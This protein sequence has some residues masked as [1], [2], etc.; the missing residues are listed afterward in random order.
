MKPETSRVQ[1]RFSPGAFPRS[2]NSSWPNSLAVRDT[3]KP[4][5]RNLEKGKERQERS[6]RG[7][8][9]TGNAT[10]TASSKRLFSFFSSFCSAEKVKACLRIYSAR[11]RTRMY[12]RTYEHACEPGVHLADESTHGGARTRFTMANA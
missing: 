10:L 3:G 11:G 1:R 9:R 6:R 4:S 7:W 5:K 2:S 12:T 8:K